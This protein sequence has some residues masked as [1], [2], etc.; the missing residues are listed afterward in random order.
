MSTQADGPLVSVV[1]PAY[2]AART[3]P[4]TLASIEAQ[5]LLDFE[6]VVVD[7][8]S[9]DDTV[10]AAKATGS[11]EVRVLSQPNSG[12]AAARTIPGPQCPTPHAAFP[13]EP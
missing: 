11:R 6:I 3:L 12:H 10:G 13:C 5:T 8:G 4:A 9:T 1:V 2:N 7:D